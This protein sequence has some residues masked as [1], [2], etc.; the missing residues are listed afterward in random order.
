[1]SAQASDHHSTSRLGARLSV[2]ATFPRKLSAPS[3]S[4]VTPASSNTGRLVASPAVKPSTPGTWSAKLACA[5]RSEAMGTPTAT[6]RNWYSAPMIDVVNQPS[7]R[8][9][10]TAST[11]MVE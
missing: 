9:W 6:G 4:A 3:T 10:T 8:R 1:M 2:T 5:T 7:V 11:G